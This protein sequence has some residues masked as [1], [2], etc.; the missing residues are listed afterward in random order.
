MKKYSGA[1]LLI[2][3]GVMAAYLWSSAG[4]AIEFVKRAADGISSDY[5]PS[6]RKAR[7]ANDKDGTVKSFVQRRVIDLPDD[8]QVWYTSLFVHPDWKSR[9][10]D[11]RLVAAFDAEP[12]LQSLKSQTHWKLYTT[13]DEWY[14]QT[15][16]SHVPVVPAL[17]VQRS[18]GSVIF[19]SSGDQ[20]AS[21]T[22]DLADAV[23][24]SIR[25]RRQCKPIPVPQP[26]PVP[27]P[28]NVTPE[29]I[30]DI[31]PQPEKPADNSGKLIL[32][33]LAAVAGSYLGLKKE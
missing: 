8:E 18:D 4:P 31:G 27:S 14:K 9:G 25:K 29:P 5:C 28:P 7:E 30:P 20:V 15:F 26:T 17:L 1:A 6:C 12:K 21:D 13:D 22:G 3:S 19:K 16:A 11:R 23:D 32:A 24:R 10:P 33:L 2:I